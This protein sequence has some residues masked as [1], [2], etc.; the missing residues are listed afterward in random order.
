MIIYC[1]EN[2]INHKRY[3][4]QSSN[5]NYNSNEEF[6][7]SKYWGSGR[8]IAYSIKKYGLENHKKWII[9][10][11]IPYTIKGFNEL[12]RYEILWIKKLNTKIPNGYNLADGGGGAKGIHKDHNGEKNPMFGVHRYG[13]ANPMFGVHRY[14]KANPMFGVHRYGKANPMFGKDRSGEKSGCNKLIKEQVI[15]IRNSNL[16]VVELSK[17]FNITEGHIGKIKNFKTWINL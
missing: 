17:K 16:T 10:K 15:E 9:I 6:Q 4:G 2:L 11:N 13:K 14:G 1:I 5:S 12:N 8:L 7:K 3:I